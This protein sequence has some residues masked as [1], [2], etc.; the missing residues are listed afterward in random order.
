MGNI[1]ASIDDMESTLVI[2]D[3]HQS[4][5]RRLVEAFGHG[6]RHVILEDNLPGPATDNYSL[7]QVLQEPNYYLP[8]V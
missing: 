8:A 1:W 7:K 6:F 5:F 2:F 4:G 3:D